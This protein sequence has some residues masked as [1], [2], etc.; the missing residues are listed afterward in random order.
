MFNWLRDGAVGLFMDDDYF[1][2]A[3]A[4]ML[5]PLCLVIVLWPWYLNLGQ[6]ARKRRQIIKK[7]NWI[8]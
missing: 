4:A 8:D 3:M 1:E 5:W 2:A 7:T 6:K